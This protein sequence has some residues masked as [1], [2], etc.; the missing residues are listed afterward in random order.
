ML[1][2][3][4]AQLVLNFSRTQNRLL[5]KYFYVALFSFFHCAMQ[6]FDYRDFPRKFFNVFFQR[7]FS[8][9]SHRTKINRFWW[10]FLSNFDVYLPSHWIKKVQKLSFLWKLFHSHSIKFLILLHNSMSQC[11][12]SIV[13]LWIA[14]KRGKKIIL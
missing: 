3:C 2:A 7:S 9:V 14:V 5:I 11:K 10:F 1:G 13:F 4:I 8:V 12:N 6:I